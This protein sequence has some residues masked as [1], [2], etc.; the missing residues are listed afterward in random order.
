MMELGLICGLLAASCNVCRASQLTHCRYNSCCCNFIGEESWT[1]L[2][3]PKSPTQ[4]LRETQR[5]VL[6]T[7]L[8]GATKESTGKQGKKHV[9]SKQSRVGRSTDARDIVREEDPTKILKGLREK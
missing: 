3:F 4:V 8:F 2:S 7:H 9:K 5:T 1:K 6:K